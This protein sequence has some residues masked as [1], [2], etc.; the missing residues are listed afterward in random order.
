[1]SAKENIT[2]I[3]AK[4][5]KF[6]AFINLNDRLKA[7]SPNHTVDMTIYTTTKKLIQI[8]NNKIMIL[9]S[10]NSVDK[11]NSVAKSE[12]TIEVE[13]AKPI[14]RPDK[15]NAIRNILAIQIKNKTYIDNSKNKLIETQNNVVNTLN[16]LINVQPNQKI[17]SELIAK[18]TQ[19]MENYFKIQNNIEFSLNK[20]IELQKKVIS[21]IESNKDINTQQNISE[22]CIKQF[23]ELK[24]FI[25][26]CTSESRGVFQMLNVRLNKI[27][28]FF[29]IL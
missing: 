19:T 5:N 27:I 22:S 14:E 10:L 9:K 23:N 21:S 11:D 4:R 20:F 16:K 1:M 26:E 7:E 25:I 8:L 2:D 13:A 18:V 24:E 15:A 12:P 17:K 29:V 6:Q 28:L 3:I